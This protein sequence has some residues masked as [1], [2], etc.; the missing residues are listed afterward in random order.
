MR[1]QAFYHRRPGTRTDAPLLQG[2]GCPGP[3]S[4]LD[5]VLRATLQLR[6]R[7][8]DAMTVD[9]DAALLKVSN[10]LEQVPRYPEDADKPAAAPAPGQG[11]GQE[12]SLVGARLDLSREGHQPMHSSTGREVMVFNGEIYNYRELKESLLAVRQN[13]CNLRWA[14]PWSMRRS[15]RWIRCRPALRAL[16][17]CSMRRCRRKVAALPGWMCPRC[18]PL[19]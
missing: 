4:G 13:R 19:R 16:T 7:V 14:S 6:L 8:G 11:L 1:I 5:R 10:R 17:S 2:D 18:W 12:K 3:F 9:L 15:T